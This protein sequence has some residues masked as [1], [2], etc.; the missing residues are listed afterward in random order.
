MKSLDPQRLESSSFTGAAAARPFHVVFDVSDVINYFRSA[1]LPTGIQ[2]VQIEVVQYAIRDASFEFS[3]ACFTKE[4][5]Y[6]IE[7][8][9]NLFVTLSTLSVGESDDDSWSTIGETLE[10]AIVNGVPF[11]F[12]FGSILLNLGS[13]WWFQNYFLGVRF[14]K[15]KYGILYVPFIHDLIPVAMPEL[16]VAELRSNFE[17]WIE[18]VFTHADYYLVNSRNTLA[19]LQDAAS[20]AGAERKTAVIALNA[21]FRTAPT[22]AKQEA[23]HD[24]AMVLRDLELERGN[25]V[26]FVSTIEPR[27]NHALVFRA[28]L[29]L[30]RRHGAQGC[31]KLVCV[32]QRGW[33]NSEA[34]ALLSA[35]DE[36]GRQVAILSNVSDSVLSKLYE[37][38]ICT[39][40]PSLYE[41][42]GLPVTESLCF[43]KVPLVSQ[44]ASLSEAGGAFAEYF[45][46]DSERAFLDAVERIVFDS[47]NRMQREHKIQA[48][49]RPRGWHAIGAEIVGH[50]KAWSEKAYLHRPQK[51]CGD[52]IYPVCATS[53]VFYSLAG[54]IQNARGQSAQ[55]GEVFRNGHG[56]WWPEPWGCWTRGKGPAKLAFVVKDAAGARIRVYLRVRG[57]Q[58]QR[59]TGVVQTSEGQRITIP[60]ESDEEKTVSI[61]LEPNAEPERQIMLTF[62]SDVVADFRPSTKGRDFRVCGL[63]VKWFYVCREDD[64]G[65]RMNFA[66]TLLTEEAAWIGFKTSKPTPRPADD[67]LKLA[68]LPQSRRK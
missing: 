51:I 60:L 31:P 58:G 57:V 20:R 36:L 68:P 50:L 13:S 39:I 55:R 62:A 61:T 11:E 30:I 67:N 49:F 3:V 23:E 53:G 66:H 33:L 45:A 8:P 9:R 1:R 40:Y 12:P 16:C 29:K 22:I 47:G 28:W 4:A 27:K 34:H 7:I 59:G 65:A 37:T 25:F 5:N 56:W 46:V 43:G 26:L 21:D 44:I 10:T 18:S 48:E 52:Y 41:G 15:A 2:R 6:W 42:W 63:G 19:D 64:I 14:A 24:V 17:E 38:C 32:G 35:S 54:E